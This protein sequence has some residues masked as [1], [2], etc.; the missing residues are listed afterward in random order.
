MSLILSDGPEGQFE[1]YASVFGA[2]DMA[3]DVVM[4]GAFAA[5]IARLG[6]GGIKLLWQ[7]DPAQP[8]GVWTE[9]SEDQRGLFCRGALN[10]D[11]QRGR[12][13]FALLRQRAVNGLSIGF[14]TVSSQ[15]DKATRTR[16]LEKIDLWEISIVTFPLLPEAR[17]GAVKQAEAELSPADRERI[18][19][20]RQLFNTKKGYAV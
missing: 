19:R 10:L 1:G 17:I 18:R 12:E 11:V 13:L 9:I 3:R 20:F 15:T 2:M 4:P 16:K 14:K 5:C 6:A 7:H 8:V